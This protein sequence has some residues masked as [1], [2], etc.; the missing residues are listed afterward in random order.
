MKDM[1]I[2]EAVGAFV[3]RFRAEHDLTLEEIADASRKNGT[4]WTA[5][6]ISAIEHGGSKADAL[7]TM[8]I[9]ADAL[10]HAYHN[11]HGADDYTVSVLDLIK[12]TERLDITDTLTVHTDS[13]ITIITGDGY[14]TLVDADLAEKL[15]RE[16]ED[17]SSRAMFVYVKR[18]LDAEGRSKEEAFDEL[19]NRLGPDKVYQFMNWDLVPT[20]AERRAA[21]KLDIDPIYVAEAAYVAFGHTLDEE[22]TRVAGEGVSPQK[23]GRVTRKLIS[24]L[25]GFMSRYWLFRLGMIDYFAWLEAGKPEDWDTDKYTDSDESIIKD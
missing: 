19:V 11:K 21:K 15:D 10:T 22:A 23:R 13:I 16:V 14:G 25:K 2:N 17:M 12:D 9:L 6:T 4:T 1:K 8:L 5:A 3:K 7:P 24:Y 18:E 20:S